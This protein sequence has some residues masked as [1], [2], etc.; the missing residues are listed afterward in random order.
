MAAPTNIAE[1]YDAVGHLVFRRC[2]QILRNPEEAKD[3]VQWTFVR[4]IETGFEVRSSAE[5]LSWLYQTASR[6]CL[7]VL[8]NARVRS[9]ILD[10]HGTEALPS[11]IAMPVDLESRELLAQALDGM[12]ERDAQLVLMTH[13]WGYSTERAAEIAGTSVRTVGRARADFKERL[14]RLAAQEASA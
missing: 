13:V 10:R 6:R 4:A 8:R 3:A 1:L 7:W 9:G 2:L 12:V 5:A 14:R 11:T